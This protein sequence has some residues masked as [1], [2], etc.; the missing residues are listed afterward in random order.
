[1]IDVID[2]V[3]NTAET[4]NKVKYTLTHADGTTEIVQIDLA[5]PVTTEGTPL[6]RALFNSIEDYITFIT[7]ITGSYIGNGNKTNSHFA[8]LGYL[9]KYVLVIGDDGGHAESLAFINNGTFSCIKDDKHISTDY[10]SYYADTDGVANVRISLET[11]ANGFTVKNPSTTYNTVW[12]NELGKTYTYV[13]Y[14]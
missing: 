10:H 1:M 9:P 11:T 5:T 14:K 3:L 4:E 6:N 12:C 2:E 7:P 13:I 8:S